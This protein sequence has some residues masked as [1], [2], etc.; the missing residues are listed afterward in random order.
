[1]RRLPVIIVL[2]VAAVLATAAPA[3][4]AAPRTY[5]GSKFT[6]KSVN[7]FTRDLAKVGIGVYRSGAARPVRRVHGRRSPLR[8]SSSQ[9]RSAALG[10]WSGAGMSG[11]MLNSLA[12]SAR[13]TAKRSLPVGAV[14]AGW[15]KRVRSPSA[16]LARRILGRQ[17]WSHYESVVFPQAVLTLFASDAA[18]HLARASR[19]RAAVASAAAVPPGPCTAALDFVNGAINNFFDAIGH[20][21]TDEKVIRRLFGHGFLGDLVKGVGDVLSTGVNV[22]V[23]RAREITLG[24]VKLPIEYVT[25]AIAGVSATVAV[26]NQVASAV[27]PWSGKIRGAPNPTGKGVGAGIPGV[28]VL[29]V[30]APGSNLKWD[31]W[32]VNCASVFKFELPDFTPKHADVKWDTSAQS[33]L[34]LVVETA[35]SGPLDDAGRAQLSF[36]TTTETPEQVKNGE[37]RRGLVQVVATVHRRDLEQLLARVT[38][39]LFKLL[40]GVITDNFGPQIRRIVD[41]MIAKLTKNITKVQD[42][43]VPDVLVVTY[44]GPKKPK[45]PA[46]GGR[47]A[48]PDPCK[49]VT[50]PEASSAAG[51]DVLGGAPNEA[52]INGL[53]TGVACVFGDPSYPARAFVRID[54]LDSSA[55]AF[56]AYETG[57]GLKSGEVAGLGDDNF[58]YQSPE[59]S[60][61]LF[62]RKS[63]IV[64]DISVL[65]ANGLPGA[66][67]LARGALG[68]F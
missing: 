23:D 18:L 64:L 30:T 45:K 42:F 2:L 38:D 37:L 55:A 1:M 62:V 67:A 33:P 48:L 3:S 36:E 46:P 19:G 15:A 52:S 58:Y 60:A 65:T 49:L 61:L 56:S 66:T 43:E 28:F 6:Q 14:I 29:D 63:N 41:P 68:R 27:L 11:A 17:D 40:P 8:L 13:I 26:V 24:A 12:G 35:N 31:D 34:G 16:R 32:V 4:A 57:S 9:A 21:H 25:K 51:M 39:N 7:T 44:H 59:G 47:L 50:Q 54:A 53:G 5:L 20:I 10:A 22:V